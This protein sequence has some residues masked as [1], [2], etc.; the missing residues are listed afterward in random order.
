MTTAFFSDGIQIYSIPCTYWMVLPVAKVDN[1]ELLPETPLLCSC[2]LSPRIFFH[3]PIHQSACPL[4]EDVVSWM[5]IWSV[6]IGCRRV[7]YSYH[8]FQM[9]VEFGSW[10]CSP[11]DMVMAAQWASQIVFSCDQAAL[12]TPLSVCLSV[13]LSVT[14][15]SLCSCH[16]IIMKF[17]GVITIDKS[18]VHVWGQGQRSK[19]KVT[20]DKKSP[21]LTQIWRFRTVT[22]VWIYQWLRNDAQSLK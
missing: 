17:S 3:M 12:K 20:R 22:L 6:F 11:V 2:V 15:F 10:H 1:N 9:V 19:V 14:P 13:C 16:R 8:S 5:I 7:C 18:D 21:I 4:L